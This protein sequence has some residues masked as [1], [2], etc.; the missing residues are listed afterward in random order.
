MAD[1]ITQEE[2]LNALGLPDRVTERLIAEASD[3]SDRMDEIVERGEA[4]GKV[5]AVV[6]WAIKLRV[7]RNL[8]RIAESLEGIHELTYEE[9]YGDLR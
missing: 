6:D 5:L 9:R 4:P 3:L 8:E 2:A 7:A 1:E